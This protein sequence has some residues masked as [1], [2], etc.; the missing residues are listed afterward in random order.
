VFG[1]AFIGTRK[2]LPVLMRRPIF[3]LMG[4]D[5]YVAATWKCPLNVVAVQYRT[6]L[7]ISVPPSEGIDR[8]AHIP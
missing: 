1:V 6:G 3:H 2:P 8:G 7:S 5:E 4:K